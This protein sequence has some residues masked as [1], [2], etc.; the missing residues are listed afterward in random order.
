MPVWPPTR[1][2]WTWLETVTEGLCGFYHGIA[3]V[4]L[5]RRN[6][7]RRDHAQP[8]EVNDGAIDARPEARCCSRLPLHLLRTLGYVLNG[9][10]FVG[11]TLIA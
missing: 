11:P 9:L 6:A 10:W 1:P 3:G 7:R 8:L 2:P 5:V 4:G